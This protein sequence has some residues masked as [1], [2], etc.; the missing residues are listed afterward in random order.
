MVSL[1]LVRLFIIRSNTLLKGF[2]SLNFDDK[3]LP[4]K[5]ETMNQS[6]IKIE[7]ACVSLIVRTSEFPDAPFSTEVHETY[8]V[9]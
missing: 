1:N 8:D 9:Q 7:Q 3:E 4:K 6:L 2:N 5:I